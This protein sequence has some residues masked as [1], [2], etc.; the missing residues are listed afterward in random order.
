MSTYK[1]N[2][3]AWRRLV[4]LV[5]N[6]GD[7]VPAVRD[8]LSIGS[9]F[10]ERPRATQ[11]TIA[12]TF[13]IR[14]PRDRLILSDSRP[15]RFDFAIAQTIWALS[16]KNELAPL[17]FYHHRGSEFSDDG[18]T[19]QS[20]IGNRIFHSNDGDQL[21]AAVN[22]IVNDRATRRAMIQIYL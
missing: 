4:R 12:T 2:D 16:G 17:T 14:N 9:Q 10:G 1:N 7:R 6:E 13:Q 15:F 21:R 11:E 19:L 18:H 22:K 5:A 3:E 8:P 20:A